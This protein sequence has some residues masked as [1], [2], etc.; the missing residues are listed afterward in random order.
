MVMNRPM[1]GNTKEPRIQKDPTVLHCHALNIRK[2]TRHP[3]KD[4]NRGL[5]T[6]WHYSSNYSCALRRRELGEKIMAAM[7]VFCS[8][9]DAQLKG[10]GTGVLAC[11]C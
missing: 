8:T 6:M 1:L 11:L 7:L 9:E 10:S 2:W 5:K 3:G 4:Q